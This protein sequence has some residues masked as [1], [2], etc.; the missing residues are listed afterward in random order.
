M[1][2]LAAAQE[3]GGANALAPV[4]HELRRRHNLSVEVL[5]S[6]KAA[7]VF[8]GAG[9]Q[10]RTVG[11]T[12]HDKLRG[13]LVEIAP[14]ALLLGTAWGPSLDKALLRAAQ[15]LKIPS[16]AVLDMW[17]NYR[18]RFLAPASGEQLLPTK[19]AVMDKLAFDQAVEA[20]LPSSTLA[21]TGQP[22][23]ETLAKR[24][25]SQELAAQASLLRQEWLATA[26][27]VQGAGDHPPNP[28][29]R[30]RLVL[31]ASEAIA[32]DFGPGSSYYRGYTEV[33]AL[34]GLVE[35]LQEVECRTSLA[36]RLVV[37]LHPEQSPESFHLGPLAK[38]RGLILVSNQPPWPCILAADVVVGMT[39]MLLLESAIAGRPTLSFQPGVGHPPMI[40]P[41]QGGI[42]GGCF[43]GTILGLVPTATAPT[44]LASALVSL[45]RGG[46]CPRIEAVPEFMRPGAVSRVADLVVSLASR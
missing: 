32:R 7:M 41:W 42:I 15:G 8:S 14:R 44:E 39:S 30:T 12:S 31:F 37:K 6:G 21:I 17:S 4:I 28:E 23:L 40:P 38:R 2:V 43:V 13:L 19:I 20:G 25:K 27:R 9:I 16:L 5:A 24:I 22:Y 34:E 29:P 10:H 1:R 36:M 33:D 11:D 45:A 18:E 3:V 26:K 35:A 46:T